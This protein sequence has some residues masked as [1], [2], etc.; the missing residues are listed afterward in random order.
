MDEAVPV[1]P[2][3]GK[4]NIM[5]SIPVHSDLISGIRCQKV[6]NGGKFMNRILTISNDRF[7]LFVTH[8]KV[9]G[10]RLGNGVLSSMASKLPLPFV[11]RKGIRGFN[12]GDLRER[13]V[14]Y[15]DVS[16]ISFIHE[17]FPCTRKMEYSR[18]SNR[19]KGK[20]EILE[21]SLHF[22]QFQVYGRTQLW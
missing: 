18:S 11:S 22:L 7:A 17:G 21:L 19:L 4:P 2:L 3:Q 20:E 5:A 9:K 15:V 16:D 1:V 8:N 13:Y 12:S 10:S 14:R 6:T